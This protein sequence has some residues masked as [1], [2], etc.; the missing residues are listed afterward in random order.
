[1]DSKEYKYTFTVFTPTYNR[2]NALN[3]VYESLKKQTI[4]DFQWLIVDDGSIDNTNKVVKN[5]IQDNI[6]DIKYIYQKNQGKHVAFNRG[7]KEAEG[8]FFLTL[9]SD[10]ECVPIALERLKYHWDNIPEDE[11]PRFSAVTSLCINEY[12]E[13]VGSLFPKNV[14]DSDSL[15]IRY[16]YKV[17]GEKWGFQRTKVL[18]D[19]PFPVFEGEKFIP[20]S[21]VWSAIAKRYKTRFINEKLRIYI[22]GDDNQ[23]TKSS[24]AKHAYG[25]YLWHLSILNDEIKYI[26][27]APKEFIRSAIHYSRFG[28]HTNKGIFYQGKKLNNALAYLLWIMTLP[29]GSLIFLLDKNK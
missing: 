1:M 19:F 27:Y 6:I 5:W 25:H 20:E 18:Q 23:L 16:K 12:G 7:V 4:R 13:V 21:I 28:F 9:D 2:E 29:L 22:T 11:K 3:R 8:E 17:K 15:E 26:K 14:I 24:P 10:D